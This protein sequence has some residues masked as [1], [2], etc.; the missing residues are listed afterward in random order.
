MTEQ[1]PSPNLKNCKYGCVLLLGGSGTGKSHGLK[2]MIADLQVSPAKTSPHLYSINVRD[3]E[4]LTE[5][6]QHTAI[7]LTK[8]IQ[9]K[10]IR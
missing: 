4:Y 1:L 9:L 5:F 6:K 3:Q 7:S 2:Q 8:L 10:I